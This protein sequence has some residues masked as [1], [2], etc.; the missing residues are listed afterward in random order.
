M[1]GN[2][3]KHFLLSLIGICLYAEIGAQSFGNSGYAEQKNISNESRKTFHDDKEL[4]AEFQSNNEVLLEVRT[5]LNYRADRYVA[6]FHLTQIG[7]NLA[8]TNALTNDRLNRFINGL[9]ILG[10]NEKDVFIDVIS[11]VP[12]Y[13]WEQDK[14]LFS[15]TFNEVPKGFEI[16]KNV[17]ISFSEQKLLNSIISIA[18]ETEIYD[19]VKMD[20]IIL[21]VNPLYAQLEAEAK[22][23]LKRKESYFTQLGVPIDTAFK[24]FAEKTSRVNPSER[25]ASYQIAQNNQ[26]ISL[27]K[28]NL[29]FKPKTNSFYYEKMSEKG[30]D[31]VL[32]P[33]VLEPCVQLM[34]DLKVRYRLSEAVKQNIYLLD[35]AGNLQNIQIPTQTQ[36]IKGKK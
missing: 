27:K 11:L 13:E 20:Y 19:F 21:D 22:K 31:V 9:K 32:N 17:H 30:Y 18:A 24:V 6:V 2:M 36:W 12:L 4:E 25:Y 34:Y 28:A 14:K 3:K 10:I 26:T 33:L 5:M 15:K 35:P 8:E 29:Q 23:V 1:I 16:Q 7:E